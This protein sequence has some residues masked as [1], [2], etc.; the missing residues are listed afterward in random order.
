MYPNCGLNLMKKWPVFL[1]K[2]LPHLKKITKEYETL[3]ENPMEGRVYTSILLFIIPIV[4]K[5]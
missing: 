4:A 3:N 1:S 2:G 5:K